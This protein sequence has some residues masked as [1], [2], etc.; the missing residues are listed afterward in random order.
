MK[1]RL[2]VALDLPEEA[3]A[4]LARFRDAA[5]DPEIWR[6]LAAETFHVT[7]AF[8]GWREPE[9]VAAAAGV[10]DGLGP[11]APVPLALGAGLLLPPRRARV[12][13][14]ALEDPTGRLGS[15]Q[16]SVS[17]RA[18][19][20]GRV[21][22]GGAAVPAPR[23]GGAAAVRRRA[24]ATVARRRARAAGVLRRAGR[25][26]SLAP[27]GRRGA[28]RGAR[29]AA[30]RLSH[31]SRSPMTARRAISMA[32]L[33]LVLLSCAA[34][35][36]A[37]LRWR[38]CPEAQGPECARI[39]VPLDRS[40]A[41][42]GRQPLQIARVELGSGRRGHM[43]YLSGGPGGAGVLE[44]VDVLLTL[45]RLVRDFDVI[46]F[47]QRGT[48]RS[49]LLRCPSLERDPRLRST[50]AGEE[51]ARRIG[52]KRAF[53]TTADTVADMEAIRRRV[54]ARK[55]TLFGISYG[56]ELALA[57]ARAYPARVERLIL[58]S[59]VDLDD[60]D[61]F[62][63]AGFRA[64]AP[65]LR[66][67]CPDG[68]AGLT[69]DPVADLTALV[70]RLRV[71][72]LR[73][74][75]FTA[76]GERRSGTVT[77]VALADLM[78]DADY[79]PALRA[80]L[81][82]AVRAA[83]DHGDAAPLLRLLQASKAFALPSR[84]RE[85][86]AGRYATVCEETPL[87]WPRGTP[88]AD[89]FGVARAL[90]LTLPPSAFAPFD[91]EVAYADEI[92][93][94]LRWP[95]PSRPP[96]ATGGALPAV[97]TLLLQGEEDLRTP[98]EASARIASLIPGAQRVTVP[99]VGH[100]IVGAD[101]SGCGPRQ[102]LRF[103]AGKPVRARCPRV[104]T[105]VPATAVPPGAFAQLP[106][107]DGLPARVGRTVAAVDATFDFLGWAL[108]PAIDLR[109]R[110]GGLRGGTYRVRGG[111]LS[112]R[113]VVVVPGVRVSGREDGAGAVRLRVSG[114]RAARGRAV[115]SAGGTLRGR[116]GGRR[117]RARLANGPPRPPGGAALARMTAVAPSPA[118][119]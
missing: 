10:L 49:G 9:A 76:E 61:P 4:A 54:G 88:L 63:L 82:V 74:T 38:G 59:T 41:V 90:A 56:T 71:T 32:V 26:V 7:L 2:F 46:G 83:L 51:C 15:L 66:A 105:D 11:A 20:R 68:C 55:L 92:D 35:A 45:P 87:P 29:L 21:R 28:I 107:A 78:Y 108:S 70:A 97:P 93:L 50:S 102:L 40:G 113:R 73:G 67:L 5:A 62:G 52:P 89:R 12:L 79:N 1:L 36:E 60:T 91:A 112:L 14:V 110:G 44:M 23:D 115:V 25:P 33:A 22:A 109:D 3:V 117:V 80:G 6:P 69:A 85:F 65:T 103:V 95:D 96:A 101:V 17:G 119:P 58:D 8:L 86:S 43:M 81:P 77:P 53:Y 42:P 16:A 111:R 106:V 27:R 13:T 114:A 34:P 37:R 75:W 19:T 30:A 72:P 64:M 84:P 116:L 18:R 24:G 57:Y 104:P 31:Y 118:R 39:H 98:P 48:G 100:A 47:D 94:C 99:G